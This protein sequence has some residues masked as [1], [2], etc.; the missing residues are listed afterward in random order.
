LVLL[1]LAY[2]SK[3]QPWETTLEK[4]KERIYQIVPNFSGKFFVSTEQFSYTDDKE[5]IYLKLVS[6]TGKPFSLDAI[7]Y[8]AAHEVA[9][10]LVSEIGHGKIFRNKFDELLNIAFSKGYFNNL[11]YSEIENE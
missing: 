9:H 4:V 6:S 7:T 11:N 2:P 10:C 8:I 1:Y 5:K 3:H